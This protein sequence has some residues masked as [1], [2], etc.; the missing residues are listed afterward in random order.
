MPHISAQR[1]TNAPV[2]VISLT[3]KMLSE[4][5]ASGS[6][7]TSRLNRNSGTQNAWMT[8]A[9]AIWNSMRLPVGSTRTGI[10]VLVPSVST[11]SKFR[12]VR[13]S[14][15]SPRT[16]P[17]SSSPCSSMPSGLDS[18]AALRSLSAPS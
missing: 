12:Y 9:D 8:S 6:G 17:T 4:W 13:S 15:F 14:G 16:A 3:W 1:P 2:L 10:S 11:L 18:I 5:L 7:I